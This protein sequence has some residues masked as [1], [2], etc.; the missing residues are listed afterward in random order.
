MKYAALVRREIFIPAEVGPPGSDSRCWEEART[1]Q[2]TDLIEFDTQ[3]EL[4]EWVR[5]NPDSRKYRLVEFT[6]LTPI[7]TL[8]VKMK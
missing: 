3:H 6:E 8:E 7:V 1:E 4:L 2:V 5:V